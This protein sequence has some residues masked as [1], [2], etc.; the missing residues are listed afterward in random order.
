MGQKLGE[1]A[2]IF[3]SQSFEKISFLCFS[4]QLRLTENM[5]LRI[6]RTF[7]WVLNTTEL[8]RWESISNLRYYT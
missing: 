4:Y 3:I 2:V 8:L 1:H 6:P 5:Y 7:L